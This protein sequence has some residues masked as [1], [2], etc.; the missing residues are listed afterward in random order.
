MAA[1]AYENTVMIKV[2][3]I[4]ATDCMVSG[5]D[6]GDDIDTCQSVRRIMRRLT[7]GMLFL[8]IITAAPFWWARETSH[9]GTSYS[10]GTGPAYPERIKS[11]VAQDQKCNDR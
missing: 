4:S 1:N 8:S 10:P 5:T 6:A 9:P 11:R 2:Q 7:T 3:A